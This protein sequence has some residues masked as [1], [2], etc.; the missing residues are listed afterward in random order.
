MNFEKRKSVKEAVIFRLL[1]LEVLTHLP[2]C[3]EFRAL[4]KRQERKLVQRK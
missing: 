4:S 2:C 1:Q 3:N